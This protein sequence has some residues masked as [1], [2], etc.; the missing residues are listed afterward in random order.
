MKISRFIVV[1]ITF[2]LWVKVTYAKEEG[3]QF[4]GWYTRI[5]DTENQLSV[6]IIGGSFLAK[7]EIFSPLIPLPGYLAI[8]FNDEK[9]HKIDIYEEFPN[10]TKILSDG[11]PVLGH[12]QYSADSTYSW[13][14]AGYGEITHNFID[15]EIPGGIEISAQIEKFDPFSEL[16]YKSNRFLKLKEP[17]RWYVYSMGSKTNY[18]IKIK[19]ANTKQ[20]YQGNGISHQ[21]K[22]WGMAFPQK[23][24]WMQAIS[25]DY[26]KKLALSGGVVSLFDFIPI[27]ASTVGIKTKKI[28]W[29]FAPMSLANRITYKVYPCQKKMDLTARSAK[30]KLQISAWADPDSFVS[31]SIPTK[32]GFKKNGG[33]ESFSANISVTAFEKNVLQE[34]ILF[35]NAALEFG[36]DY[37][38]CATK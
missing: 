11:L 21:E 34:M 1:F 32:N 24:I 2:L 37:M 16:F 5:V 6:A 13:T 38:K 26:T 7:N 17:I 33:I 29:Y 35:K 8:I 14:A 20:I 31:V 9:N 19:N 10:Q 3:P 27:K 18:E 15:I 36:G 23:W 4:E 28:N 22:N 25:A 30:R 12:N